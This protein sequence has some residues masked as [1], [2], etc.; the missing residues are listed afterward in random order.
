MAKTKVRWTPET[1]KMMKD[2]P[3]FVRPLAK[4]RAEEVARERGLET[5]TKE[6]LDELRAKYAR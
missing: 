5:M 2:V 6:L 3:F 1:E 4:R